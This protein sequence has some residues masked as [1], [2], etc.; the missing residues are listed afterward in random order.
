[1]TSQAHESSELLLDAA[2][3]AARLGVKTK[4]VTEWRRRG[5]GPAFVWLSWRCVRY[6]PSDI[7]AFIAAHVRPAAAEAK[8]VAA[9]AR[10]PGR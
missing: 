10:I 8:V 4:T 7:D 2:A 6:R 3:V 9:P 1:M 5:R